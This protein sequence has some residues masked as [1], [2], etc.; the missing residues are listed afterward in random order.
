[1]EKVVSYIN[2]EKI[3][4]QMM[5]LGNNVNLK[6][7]IKLAKKGTDN[8]RYHFH[9]E[10]AYSSNYINADSVIT[11]KRDFEYFLSIESLKDKEFFCM[12]TVNDILLLRSIL[13]NVS[14]WLDGT[15]KTFA[16]KNNKLIV[17]GK[18]E[19]IT[20]PLCTGK[21]LSF[22][23]T[24]IVNIN[25]VQSQGI[26][27]GIDNIYTNIAANTFMGFI[28]LINSINMFEAAQIMLNYISGDN[29]IGR[30]T[31]DFTTPEYQV[32]TISAK[33]GRFP[34]KDNKGGFFT[35]KLDD[36]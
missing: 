20:M 31:V 15:I 26:K 28:Y 16:I 17:L 12:I 27:M 33:D 13:R 36:M 18:H 24:V 25:D 29:F 4:D 11:I 23:P 32:E 35:N 22:E 8:R 5:F 7:N 10:Y 6:F 9:K 21:T 19:P 30:N 14:H 2:Y 34:P 1:M 3:S